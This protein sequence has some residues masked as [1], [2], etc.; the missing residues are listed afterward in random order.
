[1]KEQV[2]LKEQDAQK[3]HDTDLPLMDYSI[4]DGLRG[5]GSLCLY[6]THLHDQ[7]YGSV[8]YRPPFP[9]F[10]LR[11]TPLVILL[12]GRFWV[13]IFFTLGGFVL[14]ISFLKSRKTSSITGGILRRFPRLFIPNFLASSLTYALIR[15]GIM[16]REHFKNKYTFTDM[17]MF[18]FK[19][20]WFEYNPFFL[21]GWSLRIDLWA[22]FAVY[23]IAFFYVRT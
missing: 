2:A 20:P 3:V 5:I 16:P 4:L 23:I 15:F 19:A 8:G 17:I 21:Y 10:E 22:A 12:N 9:F 14:P 11:R 7:V 18:C 6:F 1:M 13:C